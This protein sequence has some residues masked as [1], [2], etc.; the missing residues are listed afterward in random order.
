MEIKMN[1]FEKI[2]LATDLD[3]TLLRNDKS[4]SKENLDAIEYFR[5]EG[6]MFTFITGRVPS[7]AKHIYDILKID[8]PAGCINGGGIF[9]YGKNEMLRTQPLDKSAFELIEFTEKEF[10]SIGTEVVLWNRAY[11]SKKN[12]FTEK[13]RIDEKF[14]DL[15]LN[16]RDV[17]EDVS[18][19]LFADEGKVLEELEK[20]IKNHPL[21]ENF[22][23]L[24]TDEHYFE[25]LPKGTDKSNAIEKIAKICGAGTT[26]AVG[27]NDNDALMV[28]KA[29]VGFAVS[30]AT[31][32]TKSCADFVTVSNE[33]HA[34][35][36]VIEKLESMNL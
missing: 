9:D 15:T 14:E 18:K 31:E 3:G 23:F 6:G 33:E 27:D 5:S 2:L 8:V 17:K 21:A 25:I 36:K 32:K 19:I 12:A 22:S 4:I 30:N 13:H 10:E 35:A 11:F 1:K 26:V 24:R 20:V 28:K 29:D 7:A 16:Y 34:I